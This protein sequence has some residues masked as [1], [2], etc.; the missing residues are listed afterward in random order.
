MMKELA[1]MARVLPSG[2]AREA[3]SVPITEAAPGRFS[4]RVDTPWAW[5]HCSERAR[6]S[7]S[8]PPPAGN[9][10]MKRTCL[11]P[12]ADAVENDSATAKT[13]AINPVPIVLIDLPPNNRCHSCSRKDSLSASGGHGDDGAHDRAHDHGYGR[14][15]DR[16][17]AD[18]PVLAAAADP[19]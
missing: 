18:A 13:A 8:A 11:G 7:R 14:D 9:G 15:H 2:A 4:M 5:L 16:D 17:G 1:T 12:W 10:T 19:R 6:V 3:A